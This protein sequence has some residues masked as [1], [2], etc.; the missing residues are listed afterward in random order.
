MRKKQIE[1]PAV[2]QSRV[3][4]MTPTIK[5]AWN[6]TLTALL[7]AIDTIS[8]K[9]NSLKSGFRMNGKCCHFLEEF[10]PAEDIMAQF[11]KKTSG[12]NIS[13]ASPVII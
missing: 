1:R 8:S 13:L 9:K 5:H 3:T 6:L 11:R 4:E 10:K 7:C 12:L 2:L